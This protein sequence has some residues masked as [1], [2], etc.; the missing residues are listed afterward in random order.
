MRGDFD[1]DWPGSPPAPTPFDNIPVARQ[2]WALCEAAL[3]TCVGGSFFPGI[4]GTYD[5][6]RT[7]TYHPE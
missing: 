3:E 2:A 1:A 6:A 5:I 4:E 7:A